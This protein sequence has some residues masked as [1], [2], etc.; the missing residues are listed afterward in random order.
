MAAFGAAGP[1]G[2]LSLRSGLGRESG[3][4]DR[5]DRHSVTPIF[6]IDNGDDL[7]EEFSGFGLRVESR[8]V[9]TER[10]GAFFEWSTYD[11]TWRDSTLATLAVTRGFRALPQPDERDAALEICVH[12]AR[13]RGRGREHHRTGSAGRAGARDGQRR[14]RIH[15]FSQRWKTGSGPRQP[16]RPF[17][18]HAGTSTLE[19][20]LIYERYLGQAT[21]GPGGQA[22]SSCRQG[23]PING[24]AP[25]FERFSLGDS[26]T[27]RGW[28]K[29]DIAPAGGDRMF[30]RV[31]RVPLSRPRDVPRFRIGRRRRQTAR[32]RF[33][34][35]L[36]FNPGPVFFTLGFPLNT[37][38]FRAVFTMGL[39]FPRLGFSKD[40]WRPSR[41]PVRCPL[42]S[43][44]CP[45]ALVRSL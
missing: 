17:S 8:K 22:Q 26:R 20:D 1:E 12:P 36:G 31:D 9:G 15:R 13:E 38:E 28:N 29:Y 23:G 14:H 18:V 41:V 25:L 44:Y 27:L 4:G 33:S 6:A 7:I 2:A 19:S 40:D 30:L 10:L 39:R 34:T 24:D 5:R 21:T 32:I 37:E 42:A 16:S 35:G 45:M 11:Q 43:R 3:V